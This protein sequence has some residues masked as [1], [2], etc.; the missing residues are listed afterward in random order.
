[1][2]AVAFFVPELHVLQED[3]KPDKSYFFCTCSK[4]GVQG[5]HFP[6]QY[7]IVAKI[8]SQMSVLL[9]GENQ[10]RNAD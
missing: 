10:R 7:E 2:E 9:T 5:L 3:M 1:M 8:K 4:Q 6:D